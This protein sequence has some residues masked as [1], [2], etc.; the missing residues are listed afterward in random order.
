MGVRG[1]PS[2]YQLSKLVSPNVVWIDKPQEISGIFKRYRTL[3][4]YIVLM[5]YMLTFFAIYRKFKEEAWRAVLPPI[6]AT[7]I[8]LG[9][10]TLMGETI[11]LLSVIAFALLLGVGTDYGIFLLQ[12]P[13]DRKV[14]FSISIAALMTLI[15]F[16][17]LSLSSVPALHSF[18]VAL[19]FGVSLSW[20]LTIFFA[21]DTDVYG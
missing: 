17:S 20:L 2:V 3:F 1:Q 18:G 5:G 16:G 9:I 4:S 8:T 14:L 6:F 13:G 12:Y 19:L 10:L 21:K 7:L 11:G 15:S